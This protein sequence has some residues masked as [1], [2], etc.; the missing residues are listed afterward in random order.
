MMK[1]KGCVGRIFGLKWAKLQSFL[2]FKAEELRKVSGSHR[3][4]VGSVNAPN[5]SVLNRQSP[6]W[7][8][9]L[10]IDS[11]LSGLIDNLNLAAGS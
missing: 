1:N 5:T 11:D 2:G 10:S 3:C 9:M 6:A 7:Q 4:H 8:K